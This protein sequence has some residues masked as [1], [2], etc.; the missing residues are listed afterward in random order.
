MVHVVLSKDKD[1]PIQRLEQVC[2]LG[3]CC[4]GVDKAFVHRSLPWS[5]KMSTPADM[6]S[7]DEYTKNVHATQKHKGN[8]YASRS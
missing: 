8:S 4:R 6:V 3:L 2:D 5:L 7:L 1:T